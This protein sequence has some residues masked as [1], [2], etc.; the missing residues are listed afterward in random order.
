MS[1]GPNAVAEAFGP[2]GPNPFSSCTEVSDRSKPASSGRR[3]KSPCE[4]L[5]EAILV[6]GQ[7]G[8]N[9]QP[10]YTDLAEEK[11]FA[12]FYES[13]KHYVRKL[14]KRIIRSRFGTWN[15]GREKSAA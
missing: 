11:G 5:P 3:T 8:L 13:V 2:R 1:A 4:P 14:R 6:K 9:T 10:I 12:D 15:V 7:V